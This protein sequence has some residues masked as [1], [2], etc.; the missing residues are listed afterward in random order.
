M[1]TDIFPKILTPG[2]IEPFMIFGEWSIHSIIGDVL[3]ELGPSEVRISTYGV[4]EDALRTLF[5]QVDN[6]NITNLRLLL[7]LKHKRH[8]LSM[9]MFAAKITPEIYLTG[10]HSKLVLI[11]NDRHRFGIEGSA[12]LNTNNRWENGFYFTEGRFYDYFKQKFDE[13]TKEAI[14]YGIDE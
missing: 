3:K 7:D 1:I 10:N 12:N 6:G 14:P 13:I 9:Y 5:L 8:K 4:A 2:S 11:E